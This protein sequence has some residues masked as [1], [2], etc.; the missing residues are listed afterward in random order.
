MQVWKQTGRPVHQGCMISPSQEWDGRDAD[1]VV[2]GW[3]SL[4]RQIYCRHDFLKAGWPSCRGLKTIRWIMCDI[5]FCLRS[6]ILRPEVSG[7]VITLHWL[8]QPIH[9]TSTNQLKQ[10]NQCLSLGINSPQCSIN[11]WL[12]AE[13][14]QWSKPLVS[15]FLVD[16][17]S[18]NCGPEYKAIVLNTRDGH[19]YE[20]R[21]LCMKCWICKVY[22]HSSSYPKCIHSSLKSTVK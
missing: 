21:F 16:K 3:E 17:E 2:V 13:V 15:M 4:H 14:L 7:G 6:N 8:T 9:P 18:G 5:W 12:I 19:E 20:V 1:W 22:A 11:T 10:H